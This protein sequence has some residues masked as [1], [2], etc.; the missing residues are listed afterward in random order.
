ML[1]KRLNLLEYQIF[2]QHY[3]SRLRF[4]RNCFNDSIKLFLDLNLDLAKFLNT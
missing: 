2:L 4:L 3:S 1:C